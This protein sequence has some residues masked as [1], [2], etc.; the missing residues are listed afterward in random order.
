[1][2]YIISWFLKGWPGMLL[3]LPCLAQ[4]MT[5]IQDSTFSFKS[6]LSP[7][8]VKISLQNITFSKAYDCRFNFGFTLDEYCY[9]VLKITADQQQ[10]AYVL[11]IDNTSLDTVQVYNLLPGRPKE[12]L[13]RGGNL[14]NYD[15]SRDYVWHTIPLTVSRDPH[16][17]L[18]AIKA[19][20]KN[21][22]LR[23]SIMKSGD[24]L[25]LY[26]SF[27]RTIF[28]YLGIVSFIMLI[29]II[30]FLMLRNKELLLY[31]C[32]LIAVT[33][34]I[35]AHYGYFFPWF[36]PHFP[37]INSI[38]KMVSSILAIISFMYLI[39]Y[40]L[41]HR[42]RNRL[43]SKIIVVCI[44]A[45]II[46]IILALVHLVF[47]FPPFVLAGLNISWHALLLLSACV[48]I[49]LLISLFKSGKS[50]RI[51][52]IAVA[53]PFI[54][55]FIQILSNTGYIS[56]RFLNDHGTLMANLLETLILFFG[57]IYN[58]WDQEKSRDE[59]LK[60]LEEDRK[61]TLKKLI[62]IQDNER[63]RIAEELHD[64]IGPMLAAIKINF[65]RSVKAERENRAADAL[66]AKTENIIDDSI[67]EIRNISHQLM[68]KGLS[69]KGLVTLLAEYFDDM[70]NIY[71]TRINFT[72]HITM[73]P[74]S[75]I[76][77]NLYR[78]I[79]ELVLNAAKHSKAKTI[80]VSLETLVN[81]IHIVIRDDGTGF[82]AM[83]NKTSGLGLKSI[84]SRV[85]YLKGEVDI[86][87]S[88]GNGCCV[89]IMIPDQGD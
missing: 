10:E 23:Y 56:N 24:I 60:L 8:K 81:E 2:K 50:F 17:Y 3:F 16:F 30:A 6:H 80:T 88:Q 33:T 5:A 71:H 54:M 41:K 62:T 9:I 75:D 48:I 20:S 68:P 35:L 47:P 63:K 55:L 64:S 43:L 42:Q 12:L 37:R 44:L 76:Q 67:S 51:L 11:S 45:G 77:L 70:E 57:I 15:V 14:I 49:P 66:V 36:N 26:R 73:A 34:W 59:Q 82:N 69:S 53:S 65:L 27:D 7:E 87:S 13:Y 58:I 29:T 21:V 40:L 18:I 89:K 25:K 78:I 85:S 38:I 28:F 79:S 61:N 19:L 39:F 83:K 4:S 46:L 1:M 74:N 52:S 32:Y 84:E 86:Q 22:N 72:S 31:L